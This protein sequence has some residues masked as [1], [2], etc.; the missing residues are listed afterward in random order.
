MWVFCFLS[1]SKY[2]RF[3]VFL[4]YYSLFDF[5]LDFISV[6]LIRVLLF[7]SFYNLV[8]FMS[9]AFASVCGNHN[10]TF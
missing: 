7:I 5:L 1:N 4:Y 6:Y 9:A 10:L 3:L 2:W 8:L